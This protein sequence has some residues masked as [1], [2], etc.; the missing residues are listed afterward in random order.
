MHPL[1]QLVRDVDATHPRLGQLV[2]AAVLAAK[3][4]RAMLVVAPAGTGKSA[5]SEVLSHLFSPVLRYTSRTQASLEHVAGQLNGFKGLVI[6]DD[7]G[8][9]DNVYSRKDTLQTF[10]VLAYD[11]RI[12]RATKLHEFS[13]TE[14]SG[15]V[16]MNIQPSVLS[17][18]VNRAEW[19]AVIQDKTLRYYHLFRP[20]K[21]NAQAPK[22]SFDLGIDIES[23]ATPSLRSKLAKKLLELGYIEWGV[24]RAEE[25]ITALLRAAAA[26]AKRREVTSEDYRIVMKLL[27]PLAIESIVINKSEFEGSRFLDSTL[28][29]VLVE[30]ASY[31]M[32]TLDQICRDYKVS[33]PTALG[34]L[35]RVESYL[36]ASRSST[37][38]Y[39]PTTQLAKILQR[40]GV[41]TQSLTEAQKRR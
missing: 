15:A 2:A 23:V 27:A 24:A 13:I 41:K 19:E 39:Y 10:A 31:G 9:I 8:A 5:A 14:F 4:R 28:L 3:A 20:L 17:L 35:K 16:L 11:H 32:F 34:L 29:C 7:L 38:C 26:I 18:I 22:L 6:F 40:M 30:L 21:P 37:L 36:Q 25:H 33:H 1:S 12:D